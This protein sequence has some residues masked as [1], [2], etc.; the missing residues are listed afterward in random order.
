VSWPVLWRSLPL[1]DQLLGDL[2][3]SLQPGQARLLVHAGHLLAG[4]QPLA[5]DRDDLAVGGCLLLEH[6][7][8]EQIQTGAHLGS[9]HDRI[10]AAA[11]ATGGLA[12]GTHQHREQALD[13]AER[14][15]GEAAERATSCQEASPE[16]TF[17]RG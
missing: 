3:L 2:C 7:G 16:H 14:S 17:P 15:A 5:H 1:C 4:G 13:L 10:G 8:R 11:M 9:G 6:P 12:V